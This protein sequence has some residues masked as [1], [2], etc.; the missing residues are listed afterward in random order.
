MLNINGY[1]LRNKNSKYVVNLLG[2]ET[3]TLQTDSQN[4]DSEVQTKLTNNNHSQ[5]QSQ[6]T[7]KDDNDTQVSNTKSTY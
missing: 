7:L 6:N 2:H 1:S 3:T 4:Q 5:A